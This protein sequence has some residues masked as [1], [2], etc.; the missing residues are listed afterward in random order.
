MILMADTSNIYP[1]VKACHMINGEHILQEIGIATAPV[2]LAAPKAT[3][4]PPKL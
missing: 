1:E 2:P 3:I 4:A